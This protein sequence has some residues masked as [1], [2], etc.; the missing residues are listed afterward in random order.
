MI[1][2]PNLRLVTLP[3]EDDAHAGDVAL[4]GTLFAANLIPV[5]GELAH[6]GRWGPGTVGFSA[7]CALLAGA[8]LWSQLRQRAQAARG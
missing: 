3:D 5:V 1:E 2:R 8:E 4:V 6:L 7:V